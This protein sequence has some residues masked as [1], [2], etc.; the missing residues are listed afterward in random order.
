MVI[1][2]TDTIVLGCQFAYMCSI[3]PKVL[4]F[5]RSNHVFHNAARP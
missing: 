2:I 4:E 5:F 3:F 1:Y